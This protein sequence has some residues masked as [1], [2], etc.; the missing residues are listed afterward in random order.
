[1]KIALRANFDYPN[2]V[3]ALGPDTFDLQVKELKLFKTTGI[4]TPLLKESFP[5][6][7]PSI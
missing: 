5:G 7:D 3:S 6:G 1:M 2:A 4:T